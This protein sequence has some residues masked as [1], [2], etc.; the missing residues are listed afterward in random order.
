[1]LPDPHTNTPSSVRVRPRR[2]GGEWVTITLDTVSTFFDFALTDAAHALSM[3]PTALKTVCRRL[4]I[5]RWP[6]SR[7]ASR[8]AR[9]AASSSARATTSS[10]FSIDQSLF[11]PPP[12]DPHS[13]SPD[14][15][16]WILAADHFD[17]I[18]DFS[19]LVG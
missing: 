1:M 8:A 10:P 3:S 4:G 5:A 9:A 18:T 2:K 14:T 16:P 19:Y 7:R 13:A 12:P 6:Y 11:P 15:P 17:D